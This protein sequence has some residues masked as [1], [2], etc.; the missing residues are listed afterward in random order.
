MVVGSGIAFLVASLIL[1]DEPTLKTAVLAAGAPSWLHD[2]VQ[3]NIRHS[4]LHAL[5]AAALAL[6]MVSLQ[7]ALCSSAFM[8]VGSWSVPLEAHD[9]V[10]GVEQYCHTVALLPSSAGHHHLA[11]IQSSADVATINVEHPFHQMDTP[12]C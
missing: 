6:A 9:P 1:D 3:Q 5:L 8:F 10:G 11:T 12:S 2:G 7:H 4:V